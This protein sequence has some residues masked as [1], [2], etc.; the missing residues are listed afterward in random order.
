MC[1]PF[2]FLPSIGLVL[3]KREPGEAAGLEEA[4]VIGESHEL[5]DV[6][7]S[8]DGLHILQD[9]NTRFSVSGFL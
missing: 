3:S 4:D 7:I 8:E 5:V 6:G 2:I 9:S 1:N